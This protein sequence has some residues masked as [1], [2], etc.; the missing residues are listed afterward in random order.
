MSDEQVPVH[1]G[2]IMDGNRRW[3]RERGLPVV[4][5]HVK[6]QDVLHDIVFGA[7]KRGVRYI[8]AYAFSTENWTRGEAEVG[9]LMQQ[10]AKALLVYLDELIE[11]GVRLVIVGSRD[12]LSK[13]LV[14]SIEEAE[15]R[16][17]GGERC[18]LA[19]CINYGGYDEITDAVKGI[20]AAQYDADDITPDL[21]AS[22]LYYPEL[23]PLDLII[24]TSGEQR[25]SN[26]MLWRAAYSEFIFRDEY[27]P[28]FTVDALDECLIEYSKRKRRFGG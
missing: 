24:R 22:H 27:W 26:F 3:A 6:G 19:A 21:I 13:S 23:P 25:L 15:R 9:H 16:T 5:G 7:A 2:F 20:V 4:Q 8:S 28:D 17:A 11:N 10:F 18:T 1:V 12:R 14:R